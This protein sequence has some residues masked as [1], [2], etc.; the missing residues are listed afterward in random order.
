MKRHFMLYSFLLLMYQCLC[1]YI[2]AYIHSTSDIKATRIFY[3]FTAKS[4]DAN[5]VHKHL[6]IKCLNM[7]ICQINLVR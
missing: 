2:C 6:G 5:K 1:L 7:L 4:L 3:Y